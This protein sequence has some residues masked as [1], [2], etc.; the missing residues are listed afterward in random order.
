METKKGK[1]NTKKKRIMQKK[2]NNQQKIN[3]EMRERLYQRII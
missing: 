2:E 1:N 3:R